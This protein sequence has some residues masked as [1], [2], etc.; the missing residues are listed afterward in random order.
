M[1][2]ME[3]DSSPMAHICS[4][5]DGNTFALPMAAVR[6]VP[7]ETSCWILSVATA[8]TELPDAPP[9]ESSA[10]TSGTPA[11]NIV[12]SVRV[13]RATQDLSISTP[14]T[15]SLS[16]S[17]SMNCC[18]RSL[19]FQAWKK[20]YRPPPSTPKISHQ[21][22]T[23]NSLMPITNSVGAGR[24]APNEVNTCLNEGIT[25]I[26]ITDTTTNATTITAVGYINADLIFDL[27]ASVFSM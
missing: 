2:S 12:D 19:R 27:I 8:Y 14:K 21:Y 3:P 18:T 7:V 5:M 10:S 11:A 24:S 9:T 6:L 26:M 16:S 13:Q 23:K 1:W 22:L 4:T 25:K 17:R 20:K 15:G